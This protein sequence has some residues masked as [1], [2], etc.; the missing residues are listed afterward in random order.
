MPQDP[1]PVGGKVFA[2]DGSTGYPNVNVRLRNITRNWTES[3]TSDPTDGS[4]AFDLAN[5]GYADGDSCEVIARLGP[6]YKRETFTVDIGVPPL[7][8]N[9]TLAVE[10]KIRIL[11][12]LRL[13]EE[14]ITFF[15]SNLTDPSSRGTIET[16]TQSGTGSKLSFEVPRTTAKFVKSVTV[17]DTLKKAWEDYYVDFKDKNA[18]SKPVVYFLTPPANGA[19]VDIVFTYGLSWVYPDKPRIE[20]SLDSYPRCRVNVFPIMTNEMNLGADSNISEL[21]GELTIY[22]AK[23]NEVTDTIS[24]ARRLIMENKK[25]FHHFKFITPSLTTQ[26]IVTFMKENRIIQQTQGFRILSRVE[27]IGG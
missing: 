26:P 25:N 17:N 27:K 15:R 12:F 3:F 24:E 6:F 9:L 16:N 4:Y 1:F 20:I 23:T 18:L 14:L 5:N 19:K 8:I 13:N 2:S 7:T 11:D 10:D 21:R 22:S